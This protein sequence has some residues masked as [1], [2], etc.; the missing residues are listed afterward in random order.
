MRFVPQREFELEVLLPLPLP[1]LE[2]LRLLF[3]AYQN[4]TLLMADRSRAFAFLVHYF[5]AVYFQ[6]RPQQHEIS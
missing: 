4:L 6:L 1:W 3:E 5:I 2:S